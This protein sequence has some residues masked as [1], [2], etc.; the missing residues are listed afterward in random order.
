MAILV[1]VNT[2]DTIKFNPMKLV[3]YA[4]VLAAVVILAAAGLTFLVSFVFHLT[5]LVLNWAFTQADHSNLLTQGL[6]L[7]FLGGGLYQGGKRGL[8]GLRAFLTW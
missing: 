8:R 6:L 4:V 5:L 3:M 7:L 2:T 1:Q